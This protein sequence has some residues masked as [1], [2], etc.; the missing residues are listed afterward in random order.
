M[1]TPPKPIRF[2]IAAKVARKD[3]NLIVTLT[4][5]VTNVSNDNVFVNQRFAVAPIIGDVLVSI[6]S[7]KKEAVPFRFRV[8]LGPLGLEQFVELKP[9]QTATSNYEL[10]R[11]YSLLPSGKYKV[12]ATYKNETVPKELA[13]QTVVTGSFAAE[14]VSFVIPE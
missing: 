14:P 9:D 11:G 4:S 7:P 1:T 8:R 13:N 3:G 12:Q 10:S 2:E 5:T 6:T